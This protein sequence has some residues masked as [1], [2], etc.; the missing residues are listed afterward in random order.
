MVP[1]RSMHCAVRGHEYKRGHGSREPWVPP[2]ATVRGDDHACDH[3]VTSCIAA[4][5]TA[6]GSRR[7]GPPGGEEATVQPVR[8]NPFGPTR[9]VR[10]VRSDSFGRR[11]QSVQTEPRTDAAP[12]LH[13][14]I[15]APSCAIERSVP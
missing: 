8:S 11:T 5:S 2:A 6:T 3:A 15:L 13:R 4:G 12:A 9:S 1:E 14:L 7:S 10:L